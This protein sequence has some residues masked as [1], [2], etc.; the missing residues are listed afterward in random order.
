MVL[1]WLPTTAWA[2]LLFISKDR[3]RRWSLKLF[4]EE[5]GHLSPQIPQQTWSAGLLPSPDAIALA[6]EWEPIIAVDPSHMPRL[7]G[8]K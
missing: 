3:K 7:S 8:Q 1:F 6:G 4:L 2:M 5:R